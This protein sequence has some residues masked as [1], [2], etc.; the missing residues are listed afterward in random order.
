[1]L[2]LPPS[3][4]PNERP[5]G[6][7]KSR[8]LESESRPRRN[9]KGGDRSVRHRPLFVLPLHLPPVH[10]LPLDLPK[11]GVDDSSLLPGLSPYL[12]RRLLLLLLDRNL[13]LPPTRLPWLP[14]PLPQLDLPLHR[15]VRGLPGVL[16]PPPTD[17]PPTELPH[18][19]DLPRSEVAVRGETEWPPRELLV[20][21]LRTLLLRLLPVDTGL[22]LEGRFRTCLYNVYA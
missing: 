10:R 8:L 13:L 7:P 3:E 16:P 4:R 22:P 19:A 14:L 15:P 9:E 5:R 18:R 6:K 2:P 21:R 12:L 11:V 17:L 20:A 1:M